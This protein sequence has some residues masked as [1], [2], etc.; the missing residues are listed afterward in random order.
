MLAAILQKAL[1]TTEKVWEVISRRR[2]IYTASLPLAKNAQHCPSNNGR[3]RV[4]L[5]RAEASYLV[6]QL[7]AIF[8]YIYIYYVVDGVKSEIVVSVTSPPETYC[9]SLSYLT[10]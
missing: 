4:H 6:V 1:Y 3:T 8:L 2:C 9:V 7:A 10:M 5:L